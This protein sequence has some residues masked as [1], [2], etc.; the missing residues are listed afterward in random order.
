MFT[1]GCGEPGHRSIAPSSSSIARVLFLGAK[2]GRAIDVGVV[3]EVAECVRIREEEA[4]SER[5][6]GGWKMCDFAPESRGGAMLDGIGEGLLECVMMVCAS[7]YGGDEDIDEDE[8]C[9]MGW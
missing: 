2:R 5:V 8:D 4:E 3:V 9:R 1:N 6:R 7:G